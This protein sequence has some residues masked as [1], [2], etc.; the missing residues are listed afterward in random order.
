MSKLYTCLDLEKYDEAIQACNILL[1]IRSQRNAAAGVA[2]LD[3]RCIR[4][5]VG[6]SLRVFKDAVA[7]S[8]AAATDAARRTLSRVHELLER[9]T[10]A[11]KAEP[12]LYE[13]M[14]YFNEQ[15]GRDEQVLENLLKEYRAL[16]AVVGWE[17]DEFQIRKVCQVVSHICYFYRQE[18]A[19]AGLAKCKY[20]LTGVI[21]K[22]RAQRI[23]ATTVPPEILRLEQVLEEVLADFAKLQIQSD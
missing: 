19:K 14:A 18:D 17:Q 6:G 22:V 4:A 7:K 2:S 13:T 3:E 16:Q 1:N 20:L 11:S 15:V 10:S 23:D 5:I 8:D 12:W 21:K 9:L